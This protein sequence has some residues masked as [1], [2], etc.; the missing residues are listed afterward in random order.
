MLLDQGGNIILVLTVVNE[1][2]PS[3]VMVSRRLGSLF[4]FGANLAHIPLWFLWILESYTTILKAKTLLQMILQQRNF[5]QTSLFSVSGHSWPSHWLHLAFVL[6]VWL[7]WVRHLWIWLTIWIRYCEWE[8]KCTSVLIIFLLNQGLLVYPVI[9]QHQLRIHRH[10]GCSV[11][12]GLAHLIVFKRDNPGWRIQRRHL[13][14]SLHGQV[15]SSCCDDLPWETLGNGYV[16]GYGYISAYICPH[17]Y[18]FLDWYFCLA[19]Y[20]HIFYRNLVSASQDGK[21]I[22]WDSYT[23]NKVHAIPLR[24]SWVMTCAY[25]PSGSYVACGGLDNICSIYR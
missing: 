10:K 25:A 20:L 15:N 22:V 2:S 19:T 24:S 1:R 13:Q 17:D 21:L 6:L 12:V 14:A 4:P 18:L 5:T 23:T 16:G 11:V 7:L 8:H 9:C 3:F